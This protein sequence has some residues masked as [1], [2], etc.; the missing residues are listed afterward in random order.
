MNCTHT[1][2]LSSYYNEIR[3]RQ[4]KGPYHLGGWSAGGG[5]AFACAELLIRDGEEVQS[6]III[7][8]PLPQQMET[9][10]VEFYEH[11][12]TLGL[13]GNEKPPSYL[14]PHFLRTLETMLPYQAT[15]LKTRRLPKVG[16]LWACETVMDAAGAPDIGERNHFM[17]RRRQDF[18]PDGWDT[19]LPGAEFVL[20]KAVGANHF[21]MMQKD[22]NQH[23]ARLIE[24]VVVQ[25]LAQVGY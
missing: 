11:C 9:L 14:I 5:F 10:P 17:L 2:L 13:Y 8:S 15:P 12:A 21:T 23:I 7:D 24:K 19:V 16:I 25:G 4:P 1:A 6:L 22:H 18:G 20:G 3:R